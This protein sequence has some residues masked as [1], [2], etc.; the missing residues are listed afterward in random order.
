MSAEAAGGGGG[1]GGQSR[2]IEVAEQLL[3]DYYTRLSTEPGMMTALYLEN[4][5]VI[6]T[7]KEL[8]VDAVY[9]CG[10]SE[11]EDF[12]RSEAAGKFRG[13]R[14][15][16][17]ALHPQ[18]SPTA[19]FG[20]SLFAKGRLFLQQA[21]QFVQTPYVHFVSLAPPP[22]PTWGEPPNLFIANEYFHL[23][24]LGLT[25]EDPPAPAVSISEKPE[26]PGPGR[27]VHAQPGF[28]AHVADEAV[29][30]ELTAA[31]QQQRPG[32]ACVKISKPRISAGGEY[33]YFFIHCDSAESAQLL[34]TAKTIS[35]LGQELKLA[36]QRIAPK[37]HVPTFR[38][39]RRREFPPTTAPGGGGERLGTEG[40]GGPSQ[41]S[42]RGRGQ[43]PI[44]GGN[45][46][47]MGSPPPPQRKP[48]EH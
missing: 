19:S 37:L 35:I 3:Q 2:V 15:V 39:P 36:P 23:L 4:A 41:W 25:R 27:T 43:A 21:G 46:R 42:R 28:P 7:G 13:A 18:V 34:L 16:V 48:K 47:S 33:G 22:K 14:V 31:I 1:G 45:A 6:Y 44:R 5:E 11:I 30:S 12:F 40:R 24:S 29:V 17:D 32:G 9:A 10:R 38:Q 8:T 26:P 20:I